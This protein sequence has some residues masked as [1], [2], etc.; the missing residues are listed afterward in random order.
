VLALIYSGSTGDMRLADEDTVRE[1]MKARDQDYIVCGSKEGADNCTSLSDVGLGEGSIYPTAQL[2][3]V[4]YVF[5]V[6]S[7]ASVDDV[8]RTVEAVIDVSN[9]TEPRLLSWRTR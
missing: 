3:M 8:S 4:S 2:P 6:T 7:R 1:I 9:K 5:S